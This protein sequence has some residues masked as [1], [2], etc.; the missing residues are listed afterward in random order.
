MRLYGTFVCKGCQDN[1]GDD[2][3]DYCGM[4]WPEQ[5]PPIWSDYWPVCRCCGKPASLIEILTPVGS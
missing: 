1:P 2:C 4:T 5:L 3:D